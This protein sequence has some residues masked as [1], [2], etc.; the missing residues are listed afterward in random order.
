M[1]LGETLEMFSIFL[2]ESTVLKMYFIFIRVVDELLCLPICCTAATELERYERKGYFSYIFQCNELQ[3][4]WLIQSK[5]P[6]TI[7]KWT[8][9]NKNTQIFGAEL[10]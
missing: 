5:A 10:S 1:N 9:R 6:T 8:L 3:A 4:S 7:F 2:Q